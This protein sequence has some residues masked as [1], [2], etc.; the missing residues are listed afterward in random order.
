MTKAEVVLW[1]RL[2]AHSDHGQKF[3]RQHPIGPY[4]QTSRTSPHGWS[5]RSTASHIG[6]RKRSNTTESATTFSAPA[7]GEPSA[8]STSQS[9]TMW[10]ARWARYCITW[11][12]RTGEN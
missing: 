7:A 10:R 4:A 11:L 2:R 5:L 9:T 6:Q 1:T 3:R 8:S 12:L